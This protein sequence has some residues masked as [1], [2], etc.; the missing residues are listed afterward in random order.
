M[1]SGFL[2]TPAY[3]TVFE[4]F[5]TTERLRYVAQLDDGRGFAAYDVETLADVYDLGMHGQILAEIPA[6]EQ[7]QWDELA[8]RLGGRPQGP[9]RQMARGDERFA[10]YGVPATGQ[11]AYLA[12]TLF[13]ELWHPRAACLV[14]ASPTQLYVL[15][16][17][18][19]NWECDVES[20]W[21]CSTVAY[22]DIRIEVGA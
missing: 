17:D 20:V 3:D 19:P 8:R 22:R 12:L 4:L 21:D 14:G 2:V 16:E 13:T 18:G 10:L 9:K 6:E 11:S 1:R 5:E 7:E 15:V